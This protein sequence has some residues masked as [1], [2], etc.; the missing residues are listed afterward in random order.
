MAKQP[1]MQQRILVVG[2]AQVG[3]D[4]VCP[5]CDDNQLAYHA[6]SF[7]GKACAAK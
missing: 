2:I 3:P 6:G 4:V 1:G 7:L 5:L